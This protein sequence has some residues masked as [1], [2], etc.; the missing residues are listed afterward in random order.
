VDWLFTRPAKR[1]GRQPSFWFL[2]FLYSATALVGASINGS[3]SC[4]CY[5]ARG[6]KR[7]GEKKMAGRSHDSHISI[8]I[9]SDNFKIPGAFLYLE[10][11]LIL[12][13]YQSIVSSEFASSASAPEL[14]P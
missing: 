13:Y 9:E 7:G 6:L 8:R 2:L 5:P 12:M 3:G 14:T 4:C 11:L 1:D 10:G